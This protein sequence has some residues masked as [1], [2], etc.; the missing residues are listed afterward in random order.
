MEVKKIKGQKGGVVSNPQRWGVRSVFKG[1]NTGVQGSS[2]FPGG[3]CI[4]SS[5]LPEEVFLN[6]SSHLT[7][8]T[9]AGNLYAYALYGRVNEFYFYLGMK[10]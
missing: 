10:I 7:K 3:I 8:Q 5:G 2:H 9:K 1:V 4:Y 6:L